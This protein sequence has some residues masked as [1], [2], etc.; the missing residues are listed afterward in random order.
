MER[1]RIVSILGRERDFE[2]G[3]FGFEFSLCGLL[4]DSQFTE[5]LPSIR[6]LANDSAF[7]VVYKCH[8]EGRDIKW[9]VF[10]YC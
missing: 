2:T 4:D 8:P 3:E 9:F 7:L 5:V 6:K 1:S 10:H